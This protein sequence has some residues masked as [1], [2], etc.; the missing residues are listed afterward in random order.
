MSG[1]GTRI[2]AVCKTDQYRKKVW[3]KYRGKVICYSCGITHAFWPDGSVYDTRVGP[4][5]EQRKMLDNP[6]GG[7]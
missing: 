3:S 7:E 2:C 6:K 1:R 5:E 4:S